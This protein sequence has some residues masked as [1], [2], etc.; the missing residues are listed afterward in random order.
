MGKKKKKKKKTFYNGF[1][2]VDMGNVSTKENITIR[3]TVQ[4]GGVSHY[5]G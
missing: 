2:S 1:F 3:I 5:L 4:S